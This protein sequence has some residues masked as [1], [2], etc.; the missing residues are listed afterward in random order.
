VR[1]RSGTLRQQVDALLASHEQAD[2]FLETPAAAL[3]DRRADEL[4]GR[5]VDSYRIVAWIGAGGMGGVYRAHDTK[6]DRP[7][8]LKLLPPRVAADADRLH[9]F[10]AEARAAS[11]LNHPNILVIHDF[12]RLDA[13]PFIVSELVEG[14][15]L[16]RRLD[17]GA[18]RSVRPLRL[19]FRSPAHWPP[20]M[21]AGSPTVTSNLKTSW[22]VRMGK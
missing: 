1:R 6:L 2:T 16:R 21:R 11:S 8:A 14:E 18:Y 4:T 19:R 12:G 20:R 5:T 9:R 7:V 15:T 22:C 10:H 17:R 13:R 3:L